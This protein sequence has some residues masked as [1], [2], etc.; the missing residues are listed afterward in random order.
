MQKSPLRL[1]SWDIK[2]PPSKGVTGRGFLPSGSILSFLSTLSLQCSYSTSH[3][4]PHRSTFH[5]DEYLMGNISE[6]HSE[7]SEDERL[8]RCD[9]VEVFREVL[10]FRTNVL[11][12]SLGQ[13]SYSILPPLTATNVIWIYFLKGKGKDVLSIL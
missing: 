7:G 2:D 6:S 11:L 9:A 1:F 4:D 10:T 5:T 13:R 8:V 3:K 12:P